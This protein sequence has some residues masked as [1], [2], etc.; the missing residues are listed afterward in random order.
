MLAIGWAS[1]L[2][3]LAGA[4]DLLASGARLLIATAMLAP[5]FIKDTADALRFH[6][7]GILRASAAGIFLSLHFAAWVPSLQLTTIAASTLL[8]AT[9][10]VFAAV[11]ESTLLRERLR[12]NLWAGMAIALAGTAFILASDFTNLDGTFSPRALLGDA[13]A[14]LGA[15]F[16]ACYFVTGRGARSKIKIGPYLVIVNLTAGL[17]LLAGSAVR[18]E[19][20]FDG[21]TQFPNWH[22]FTTQAVVYFILL[23]AVPQLL[24]HGAANVA[25]RHY[26]ATVVNLAVLSEPVLATVLAYLLFNEPPRNIPSFLAGGAILLAGLA[27]AIFARSAPKPE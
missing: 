20:W 18:G 27:I 12:R 24:G 5:F 4:P 25:M 13:L 10:P 23:A 8:V 3:R 17:L 22:G 11:L 7:A 21:N 6:R 19:P 1:P 9:E 16:G 26:P 2:F 14:L 15:L